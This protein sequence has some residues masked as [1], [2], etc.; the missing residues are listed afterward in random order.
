M[1][2]NDETLEPEGYHEE[3]IRKESKLKYAPVQGIV[4]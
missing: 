3:T 2:Y 1:Y 4:P